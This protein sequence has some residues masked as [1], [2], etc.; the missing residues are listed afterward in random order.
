MSNAR[1][2]KADRLVSPVFLSVL[3]ALAGVAPAV[4]GAETSGT[5]AILARDVKITISGEPGKPSETRTI[6][7]EL[8]GK[9]PPEIKL[10]TEDLHRGKPSPARIDRAQVRAPSV[11]TGP[12]GF[13]S[14]EVSVQNLPERYGTYTG[15]IGVSIG[16]KPADPIEVTLY[17]RV[18]ASANLTGNPATVSMPLVTGWRLPGTEL[19]AGRPIVGEQRIGIAGL[20][21]ALAIEKVY[22]PELMSARG[23]GPFGEGKVEVEPIEGGDGYLLRVNASGAKPDKYSGTALLGLPDSDRRVS[24]PIE[25]LVRAGPWCV[26]GMLLIGILLGRAAKY[27]NER[28][29]ALLTANKRVTDL[30]ARIDLIDATHRVVLDGVVKDLRD[31]LDQN[32]LSELD[33]ALADAATR[34]ALLEQAVR[35]LELAGKYGD[36]GAED[37]TKKI[38]VGIGLVTSGALPALKTRLDQVEMKVVAPAQ[39]SAS[40]EA[41]VQQ[42]SA[43]KSAGNRRVRNARWIQ[44]T[45]EIGGIVLLTFVGYE[46]LY[47]SG[48][49]T[50]GASFSDYLGAV[51]WGLGAD[52]AGR[53]ITS[54]GRVATRT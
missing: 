33:T 17:V 41:H 43:A 20:A 24:V 15:R 45:L 14:Y 22:P 29:Q 19:L 34:A 37:E 7:F 53:T 28:G 23:A 44:R 38:M 32:R 5:A 6:Q 40:M 18:P 30:I 31:K 50:F 27:M 46:V 47:L 39:D 4:R 9:Q 13:A 3:L 42:A 10:V 54:L 21:A 11:T 16:G 25:V 51:I 48:S 52:V 12:S 49:P 35:V 8:T 1:F 26:L 2:T 36:L